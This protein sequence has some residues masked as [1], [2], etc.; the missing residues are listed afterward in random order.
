VRSSFALLAIALCGACGGSAPPAQSASTPPPAAALDSPSPAA[1]ASAEPPASPEVQAGIKAFDAGRY[2]DAKTSFQAGAKKNPNDYEALYNLGMTCEKLGDSQ[3]A[4][5]AYKAALAAKPGLDTASAELCALY[6]D[7]GRVE[8]ALAVGRAGLAA[9]PDSAALHENVGVALA[10]QGDADSATKELERAVRIAPS[11][12]MVHL[13]LAHWLNVWHTPGAASHL[14]TAASLTKGDYA[15]MLSIGYEYRMAAQLSSCI[16]TFDAAVATKDGGEARTGRAL[17]RLAMKDEAGGLEDL[18]AAVKV[19]PS[20][21]QAHYFLGGRLA[22]A[23]HFKE[24]AAEYAEYLKLAPSGS[25]AKP[26]AEKL[27]MAQDAAAG[28]APKAG[29]KK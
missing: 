11:N 28:K 12:P 25:L 24:A 20:Y 15:M 14:D 21:P 23:K 29:P 6:V 10:T 9:H 13:T 22:V 17:C 27:K 8:E 26:A 2:A 1:S 3:G 4:E 7:Q 16:K 18:Q 5:A 19:E